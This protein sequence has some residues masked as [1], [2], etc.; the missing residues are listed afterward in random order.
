MFRRLGPSERFL[1][2]ANIVVRGT[3]SGSWNHYIFPLNGL[4]NSVK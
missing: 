4:F 1:I 3:S 2:Q